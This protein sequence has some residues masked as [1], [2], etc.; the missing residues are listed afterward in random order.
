MKPKLL[1]WNVRGI[2]EEMHLRVKNLL[3]EWKVDVIR[4]EETKMEL[5]AYNIVRS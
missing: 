1:Y 3:R 4:L 5:M 2:N